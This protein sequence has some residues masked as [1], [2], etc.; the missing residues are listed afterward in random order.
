MLLSRLMIFNQKEEECRQMEAYFEES[1]IWLICCSDLDE[2]MEMI[3]PKE[4]ISRKYMCSTL[5][6][7]E[8]RLRDH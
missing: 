7:P 4:D 8:E 5:M 2:L 3:T 1:G 6:I